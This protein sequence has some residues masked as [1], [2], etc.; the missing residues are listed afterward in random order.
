MILRHIPS[1]KEGTFVKKYYATGYGDI[2]QI[3]L[4]N[5]QIYYAPSSEFIEI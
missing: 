2:T 5:N 4:T 1:L 3:R